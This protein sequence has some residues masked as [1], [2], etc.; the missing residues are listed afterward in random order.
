MDGPLCLVRSAVVRPTDTRCPLNNKPGPGLELCENQGRCLPLLASAQFSANQTVASIDGT[1]CPQQG[2]AVNCPQTPNPSIC[3]GNVCVVPT[4]CPVDAA[5]RVTDT[6][7]CATAAMDRAVAQGYLPAGTTTNPFKP[8][9]FTCAPSQ[10]A[11]VGDSC[12]CADGYFGRYCDQTSTVGAGGARCLMSSDGCD[13]QNGTCAKCAVGYTGLDCS[14]KISDLTAGTC[15]CADG[16]SGPT[17]SV[18]EFGGTEVWCRGDDQTE[19]L[20][21]YGLAQSVCEINGQFR[22]SSA[23]TPRTTT[24]VDKATGVHRVETLS[25]VYPADGKQAASSIMCRVDDDCP[26]SSTCLAKS[27]PIAVSCAGTCPPDAQGQAQTCDQSTQLCSDK[28]TACPLSTCPG[29]MTCETSGTTAATCACSSD[30]DCGA[31]GTCDP[32][33]KHCEFKRC[34]ALPCP[35]TQQCKSGT[36][37]ASGQCQDGACMCGGAGQCGAGL[38]CDPA[39][40]T[41][42]ESFCSEDNQCVPADSVSDLPSTACDPIMLGGADQGAL[43]GPLNLRTGRFTRV[44][45]PGAVFQA[46]ATTKDSTALDLPVA[47]LPTTVTIRADDQT[48]AYPTTSLGNQS[49]CGVAEL[50]LRNAIGRDATAPERIGMAATTVVTTPFGGSLPGGPTPPTS[51]VPPYPRRYCARGPR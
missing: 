45:L 25:C 28:K 43:V 8:A 30:A 13:C 1:G 9:Q 24:V 34:S 41:C 47:T 40:N 27:V 42:A 15:Q 31:G 50:Q 44:P 16:W 2:S 51:Y 3:Q 11:R 7:V 36:D 22:G 6:T 39:T 26:G 37:C 35:N 48:T 10:Q 38:A 19:A 29:G 12:G 18:G 46:S 5:G 14:V 4:K 17:C 20:A 21:S 32:T 49:R 33:S 23:V